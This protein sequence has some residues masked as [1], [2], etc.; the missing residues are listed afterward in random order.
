MLHRWFQHLTTTPLRL[1]RCFPPA[2]LAAIDAEITASER[3]HGAELCCAV[4][5]TLPIGHLA[6][7]IDART[8]AA[9]VFAHLG[10]WDTAANNGVLLYILLA[11]HR[12]E[13]VADR[14]WNGR[15]Q[16]ADWQAIC[17]G[18]QA[19]CAAGRYREGTVAALHRIGHLARLHFPPAGDN[20]NELPDR[21]VIL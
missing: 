9:A 6:R 3:L 11:E 1:R 19:A 2:T 16:P 7:G 18:L 14:G 20:P 4:E 5:T 12:I 15:V 17:D 8:R 10:M 21:T 13:I